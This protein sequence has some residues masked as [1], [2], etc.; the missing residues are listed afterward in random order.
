[1]TAA[2]FHKGQT[3]YVR[4]ERQWTTGIITD[5]FLAP[6]TGQRVYVVDGKGYYEPD[7]SELLDDPA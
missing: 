6:V 5:L 3:V 4:G 7:V 1:M 2:K